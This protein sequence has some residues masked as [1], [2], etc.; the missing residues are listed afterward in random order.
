MGISQGD[1]VL[2]ICDETG[3]HVETA[4][5]AMNAMQRHYKA[6]IPASVDLANELIAERRFA[7]EH[8]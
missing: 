7:A 2:I 4:E 8:E 6:V 5:Q 1:E 3:I